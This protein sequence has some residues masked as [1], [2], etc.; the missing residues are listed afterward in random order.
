VKTITALAADK[1]GKFLA[2]DF[3]RILVPR[4]MRWQ[5]ASAPWH[6]AH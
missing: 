5:N 1:P 3:R 6:V 2:K 4:M